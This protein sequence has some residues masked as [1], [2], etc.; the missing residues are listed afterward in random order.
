[1]RKFLSKSLLN[2]AWLWS[3]APLAVNKEQKHFS[4]PGHQ[5]AENL[6][7]V[8]GFY[9]RTKMDKRK[10]VT[11]SVGIIITIIFV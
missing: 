11:K 10:F 9:E 5:L 3:K 2:S 8:F 1:M 4:L 6:I 7:L